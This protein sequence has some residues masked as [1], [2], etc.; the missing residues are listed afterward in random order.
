[1]DD[2]KK[3]ILIQTGLYLLGLVLAGL[4]WL[5]YY[6][7]D[8]RYVPVFTFQERNVLITVF[9]LADLYVMPLSYDGFIHL[10]PASP[11]RK[12]A[13][14]LMTALEIIIAAEASLLFCILIEV[15]YAP[16]WT[17]AGYVLGAL[18][19]LPLLILPRQIYRR[20]QSGKDSSSE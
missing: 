15:L 5:V 8:F 1:M 6:L 7:A 16:G 18:L 12:A 4:P 20:V 14:W 13:F 10:Y 2:R 9:L 11:D 17:I 19:S 3:A